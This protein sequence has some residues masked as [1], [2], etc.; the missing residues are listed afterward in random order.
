MNATAARGHHG[1]PREERAVGAFHGTILTQLATADASAVRHDRRRLPR[2]RPGPRRR[3][4]GRPHGPSRLPRQRPHLRHRCGPTTPP[5]WS[6][7]RPSSRRC[8]CDDHP[9]MFTPSPGAWGRGGCTD[10]HPG[11]GREAAG[12]ARRDAAGV[13]RRDGEAAGRRRAPRRTTRRQRH[14][15]RATARSP[16]AGP[17]DRYARPANS[18]V[19]V[20][21]FT[22]SPSLMKS[23]TWISQPGLGDRRLG[24][25]AAG[26]VA[27]RA[28]LGLGDRHLDVRRELDGNR[29]AVE[30]LHLHD[31]L[32]TSSPLSSPSVSAVSDSVSKVASSMKKKASP[33]VYW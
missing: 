17:T 27:A 10:V 18:R 33:S 28:F 32:S 8:S 12:G 7:S 24:D 15:A 16:G 25:A 21:T 31:T 11:Q 19:S 26:G 5:A 29:V 1:V 22:L 20:C 2:H 6:S 9:A 3:R 13:A 23:G 4:R 14:A 30:L